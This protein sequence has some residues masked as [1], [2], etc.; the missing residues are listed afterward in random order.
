[1][2]L[3]VQRNFK[4]LAKAMVGAVIFT[5]VMGFIGC[6]FWPI[7]KKDLIGTYQCVLEDGTPGLPDGGSETLE[8]Y[9]DGTC[10]QEV[11]LKD[12][13]TFST[14]ATWRYDGTHKKV[15]LR[16]IYIAVIGPD[17][18]NPD[19]GKTRDTSDVRPIGRNLHGRII[20]GS[21]LGTR[22]EKK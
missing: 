9:P 1:M 6:M 17:E 10:M 4:Q 22:Y 8:L 5:I 3:Q 13:A 15:H 7:N 12:G 21:A 16:G 2:V 18:I 14:K 19:M 20:L 11:V